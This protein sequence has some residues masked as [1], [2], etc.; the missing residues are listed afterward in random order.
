MMDLILLTVVSALM[1]AMLPGASNSGLRKV[2][3]FLAGLTLLLAAFRPIVNSVTAIADWPSRWM[4]QILPEEEE[5]QAEEDRAREKV[6]AYSAQNIER[7]VEALVVSRYG[8][9]EESVSSAAEVVL[10][11]DGQWILKRMVIRMDVSARCDDDAVAQYI[12]DILACPCV[13]QRVDGKKG[14]DMIYGG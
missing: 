13:V 12:R 4:E 9:S 14:G 6:L 1:G 10:G 3:V 7:G 5:L 2:V 8:I 11:A